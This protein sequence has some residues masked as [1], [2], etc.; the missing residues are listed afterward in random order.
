MT[1]LRALCHLTVSPSI[2]KPTKLQE[3]CLLNLTGLN[4]Q[5]FFLFTTTTHY[6]I[7]DFSGYQIISCWPTY[8]QQW[9]LGYT[10]VSHP[11]WNV[12]LSV[13]YTE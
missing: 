7:T 2:L 12:P 13:L 1:C 3:N 9:D 6:Q 8:I 10:G 4:K 11:V 5:V